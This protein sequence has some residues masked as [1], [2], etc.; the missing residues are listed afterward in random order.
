M[1]ASR[2]SHNTAELREI[3]SGNAG[4]RETLKLM[5]GLVRRYKTA[6]PIRELA[7]RIID[8]VRG[9]KQFAAQ[10]KAV[11]QFIRDNI[12]YV[13]DVRGVETLSTPIKTLEYRKGDCDD[14]A[15]LIASLLESIGHPTRFVAIKMQPFGPYVHVF[16]ET[17]IGNRWIP[18]ET[19]ELWPIGTH[20]P[21]HAGRLV[22]NN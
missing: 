1:H 12:Q 19:T 2:A 13:R 22:W 7:L 18:L 6:L 10:V 8:R 16:A 15:V 17:K 20:P 21:R 5:S 14:Q 4:T 3:P 9:H 11:H